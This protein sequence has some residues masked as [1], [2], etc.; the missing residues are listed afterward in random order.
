MAINKKLIHFKTFENFNSKKLSA[1]EENTQYTIG[2]DGAVTDGEPDVKYQSICWIKD[3][4]KIWTHS[5]IY[6]CADLIS[7]TNIKTINGESI[8]GNGNIEIISDNK[9]TQTIDLVQGAKWISFYVQT[10]LEEL[11][12][13]LG[14][15][16]ITIITSY[17][18]DTKLTSTYNSETN[19]WSGDLTEL[20]FTKMYKITC[21]TDCSITLSGKMVE[22]ISITLN[23]GW[24][25]IGY[26]L[27]HETSIETVFTNVAEDGD[28]VKTR[29]GFTMY[30]HGYWNGDIMTLEPGQGYQYYR[31][32]DT[33]S[34]FT[35]PTEL[36]LKLLDYEKKIDAAA[37]LQ[38]A[39]DYVDDV[40][41]S[42]DTKVITQKIHLTE[43][44]HQVSFYVNITLEELQTALGTNGI[45]I[46]TTSAGGISNADL[47]NTYDSITNTW[48][49]NITELD[50]SKMYMIK[51]SSE[52]D[53]YLTGEQINPADL[54][55]TLQT[56]QNWIGYPINEAVSL[57]D[58][59][60]TEALKDGDIIK[61][62]TSSAR[63]YVDFEL[64]NGNTFTGWDGSLTEMKP[65][66]GYM[67]KSVDNKSLTYTDTYY[68]PFGNV[69][70]SSELGES[71]IKAASQDLVTKVSE[72]SKQYV[73]DKIDNLNKVIQTIDLI[74]GYNWVS[75]YVNITLEQ[76]ME[77]VMPL[78][79]EGKIIQISSGDSTET[80][81][82]SPE[83]GWDGELS[84]FDIR[85]F[86]IIRT[87]EAC[88]LTIV[89]EK[90]N[91]LE[92]P[93]TL[94][95]GRNYIS[96]PL[97]VNT[98]V[99]EALKNMSPSDGDII[100]GNNTTSAYYTSDDPAIPSAWWPSIMLNP[101]QGY[102]YKSNA[103]EPITF[104][105][106][107]ELDIALSTKQDKLVS[108]T[109]IKTVNGNS[110]LGNGD[111]VIQTD[112]NI[113]AIDTSEIIDDV[114]TNT[115]VK[116]VIQT[117]TEEQKSQVRTNIGAVASNEIDLSNYY[118]K[119]ETDVII[120]D[121][122]SILESIINS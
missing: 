100:D 96:Y 97:D 28:Q 1:N 101:G 20:D 58:A 14:T 98:E 8:L 120:G 41:N 72:E 39:K 84:S 2:I 114:E 90:I 75:F 104:T 103:T 21:S 88:E 80:I 70:V 9:V 26:P 85:S 22:N 60:P 69:E 94:Q 99:N 53:V 47:I 18:G 82:Y 35:H 33:V 43:G 56:G 110:I 117:L 38:E 12:T 54:S 31:A 121:I 77:A 91:P 40:I 108:G 122:N 107:T 63:Y 116:Y 30:S 48:S 106:P 81:S 115:Y 119:S 46:E 76:L 68:K 92:M 32:S 36:E 19:T 44:Y 29:T 118:T 105:Y 16:G 78:A 89:G 61:D 109:N 59:I 55:I 27:T 37:K 42:F 95:S 50:L 87:A 71:T 45:S 17:D 34:N 83:N 79:Q 86:I 65:G 6:N 10:T 4:Q 11:Q 113:K 5:T 112:A 13:A 74:S 49:G 93:I 52:C 57:N 102:M 67:F 24:N 64:P 15:N 62:Q 51:A 23:P 25:W 66:Q 73:D 7:G 111:I 3:V